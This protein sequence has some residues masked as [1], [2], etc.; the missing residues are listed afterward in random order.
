MHGK[1]K[2]LNIVIIEFSDSEDELFS[3]DSNDTLAKDIFLNA[4]KIY[5]NEKIPRKIGQEIIND[6]IKLIKIHSIRNGLTPFNIENVK[7]EYMLFKQLKKMKILFN[8]MQ[9][10]GLP[11]A[12]I[13][14]TLRAEENPRLYDVVTKFLINGPFGLSN[15]QAPK[16]LR[17]T[18]IIVIHI[19]D[20]EEL[21]KYENITRT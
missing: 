6:Q 17:E 11:H 18:H 19:I 20:Q 5:S 14:I 9:K 8:A 21:R 1:Q 15:L 10:R 4:L 12:H 2:F 3:N 13:L 16:T 7:S